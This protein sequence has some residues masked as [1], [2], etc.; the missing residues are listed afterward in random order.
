MKSA[1][2]PSEIDASK[3]IKL[4]A[5]PRSVCE[6]LYKAGMSVFDIALN[7]GFSREEIRKI[8]NIKNFEDNFSPYPISQE[9]Q[10]RVLNQYTDF[11]VVA[12]SLIVSQKKRAQEYANIESLALRLGKDLL[13]YYIALECG[14]VSTDKLKLEIVDKM[15]ARTQNSRMQLIEEYKNLNTNFIKSNVDADDT[16]KVEIVGQ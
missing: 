15:L 4:N 9:E 12:Q 11:G 5:N 2:L 14:D 6:A 10:L 13:E 7:L 1:Y 8:L 16:V 3:K